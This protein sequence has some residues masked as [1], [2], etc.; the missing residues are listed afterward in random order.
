MLTFFNFVFF[1][2]VAISSTAD[3]MQKKPTYA[4]VVG[5]KDLTAIH[6]DAEIRALASQAAAASCAEQQ[7]VA[8][9]SVQQDEELINKKRIAL[10]II[11]EP[12]SSNC[13][14]NHDC[15]L[16][17]QRW[18]SRFNA[19]FDRLNYIKKELLTAS[20]F[21]KVNDLCLW[22]AG[23]DGVHEL[24]K[25]LLDMGADVNYQV[26]REGYIGAASLLSAACWFQAQNGE[27]PEFKNAK[28]LIARGARLWLPFKF[29]TE[30]DKKP[31][32]VFFLLKNGAQL[33]DIW[34]EHDG[35]HGLP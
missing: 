17:G 8:S 13:T 2:L 12:E 11:V 28:L 21:E 4:S 16:C 10:G 32:A 20:A 24:F 18:P 15:F 26:G 22:A 3:A 31:A 30:K 35:C 5:K 7:Q 19:R 34:F 25:A 27:K 29:A 33:Q 9:N 6:S 14:I 23:D 1:I